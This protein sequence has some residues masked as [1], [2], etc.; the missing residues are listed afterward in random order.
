M[1]L[2]QRY[3]HAGNSLAGRLLRR[4]D[5]E[6]VT[7][8]LLAPQTRKLPP[9]EHGKILRES[10]GRNRHPVLFL[11]RNH[12]GGHRRPGLRAG[13]SK[14]SRPMIPPEAAVVGPVANGARSPTTTLAADQPSFRHEIN[15][16][17]SRG[18]RRRTT[19][20]VYWSS[21]P[22]RGPVLLSTLSVPA[23]IWVADILLEST[24]SQPGLLCPGATDGQKPALRT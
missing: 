13:A 14:W 10:P 20:G 18:R 19:V 9:R 21:T 23:A 11:P 2:G 12:G 15:G 7:S 4:C 16:L 8:P 24:C 6:L 22:T 3:L 17:P 1:N 5:L